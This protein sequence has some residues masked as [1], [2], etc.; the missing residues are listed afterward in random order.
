MAVFDAHV[1]PGFFTPVLT[2]ISFQVHRL[3]FSHAFNRRKYGGKKVC[4]NRVSNSQPPGHEF[5]TLTTELPGLD[6]QAGRKRSGKSRNCSKM[7]WEK[8]KLFVTSN[9][10]F[11]HSVFKRLP[12]QIRNQS[13]KTLVWHLSRQPMQEISSLKK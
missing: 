11:S 10:S 7:Q 2:L 12:L 13:L 3:L 8:E 6:L 9:F 1:F 4:L 5:D